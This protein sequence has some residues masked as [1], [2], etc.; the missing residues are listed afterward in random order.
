VEVEQISNS[1]EYLEQCYLLQR[2]KILCNNEKDFQG[3]K[4]GPRWNASLLSWVGK[5]VVAEG[6]GTERCEQ[7]R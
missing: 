1:G 3:A 2:L 7:I 6:A 5:E 4:E